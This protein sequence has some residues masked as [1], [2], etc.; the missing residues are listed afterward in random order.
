MT[1]PPLGWI[2]VMDG[3][4]GRLMVNGCTIAVSANDEGSRAMARRASC[5]ACAVAAE[6]VPL[7]VPLPAA[8]TVP[9]ST[10]MRTMVPRAEAAMLTNG[11]AAVVVFSPPFLC[12]PDS[13]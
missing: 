3:T 11:N 12:W 7:T 1:S 2:T 13:P 10:S 8:S 5:A 4:S 9:V 6:S